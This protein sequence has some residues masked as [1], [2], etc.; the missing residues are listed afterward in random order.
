M[1]ALSHKDPLVAE[2][3][4]ASTVSRVSSA[5]LWAVRSASA[6]LASAIAVGSLWLGARVIFAQS[7]IGGASGL[8]ALYASTAAVGIGLAVW[9]E[10]VALARRLTERSRSTPAKVISMS[11]AAPRHAETRSPE[12]TRPFNA[13]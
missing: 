7:A 5:Q 4:T 10:L 12:W 11:P 1:L 6:A 3:Q 9:L 8:F 2:S 13:A